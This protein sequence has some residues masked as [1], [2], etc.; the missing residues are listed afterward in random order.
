[1]PGHRF[2]A[3]PAKGIT[4]TSGYTGTGKFERAEIQRQNSAALAAAVP[5]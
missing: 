1:M 5:G 3:E 2:V 4:G